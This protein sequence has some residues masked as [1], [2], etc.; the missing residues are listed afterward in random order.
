MVAR[1]QGLPGAVASV[2]DGADL[3]TTSDF[4]ELVIFMRGWFGRMYLK[5]VRRNT[6]RVLDDRKRQIAETGS[7]LVGSPRSKRYGQR[8]S[9][10]GRPGVAAG[11][12]TAMKSAWAGGQTPADFARSAGIPAS[13]AR[14]YYRRFDA[15]RNG[16]ENAVRKTAENQD[17]KPDVG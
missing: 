4:G 3:D 11:I 5:F 10:L 12:V 15:A 13:T 2:E 9:K 7:F 16:A 1:I 14:T 6:S 17:G 8:V